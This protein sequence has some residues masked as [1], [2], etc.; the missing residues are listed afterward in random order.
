MNRKCCVCHLCGVETKRFADHIFTVHHLSDYEAQRRLRHKRD[1]NLIKGSFMSISELKADL[2]VFGSA[3]SGLFSISQVQHFLAVKGFV[4]SGDDNIPVVASDTGVQPIVIATDFIFPQDGED[5]NG[6]I[7]I[8]D[9]SKLKVDVGDKPAANS[10]CFDRCNYFG[11]SN[12]RSVRSARL[13][14]GLSDH[15]PRSDPLL[16]E[17]SC[18]LT[19]HGAAAKDIFNKVRILL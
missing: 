6:Q 16:I 13:N 14:A 11:R 17:F 2:D 15:F 10:Q 19:E 12:V 1:Y 3:K 18:F 8:D 7:P 5:T 4:I 9:D